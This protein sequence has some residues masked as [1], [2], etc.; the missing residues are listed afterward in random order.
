[1]IL[2]RL[3]VASLALAVVLGTAPSFAADPFYENLLAKGKAAL[4]QGQFSAAAHDLRIACFGL[5]DEPTSLAVGLTQLTLA[6]HRTGNATAF[7]EATARLLDLETRFSAYS[8]AEI[9]PATRA[10]FEQR[11]V[12]A[13]PYEQLQRLPAFRNAARARREQDVRALPPDRRRQELESL[14]ESAPGDASWRIM[15]AEL[16]LSSGRPANAR[17]ALAALPEL[18]ANDPH[19]QCLFGR[20]QAGLGAC[21]EAVVD[22]KACG[23]PASDAGLAADLV[24]CLTATGDWQQAAAVLDAV[25]AAWRGRKPLRALD[26]QTRRSLK[27]QAAAP[28]VPTPM[29]D[30][31]DPATVGD[32]ATSVVASEE[33]AGPPTIPVPA[34]PTP[35][36]SASQPATTAATQAPPPPVP[37]PAQPP[38][39]A[40]IDA[41]RERLRATNEKSEMESLLEASTSLAEGHPATPETQ[42]LV[43]EVA[44]R[45][46]RWSDVVHF[47]Q[48]GGVVSERPALQFY[49]AIALYETGDRAAAAA[50]MRSCL[51]Q[52]QRTEFVQDYAQKI[53]GKPQS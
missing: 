39:T 1:M 6:H 21:T 12:E 11:L 31:G 22:L 32:P 35:T 8:D 47:I 29:P 27:R 34:P 17:N 10:A 41:L 18:R 16:D 13:V 52:L 50:A 45:L 26:R 28:P 33:S 25:P 2:I 23:D 14:I 30:I 51:P 15:L 38:V 5:L 44:Y 36:I 19:A 24:T 7:D 46:R 53:L 40:R 3:A 42:F 20:A 43:A 48:Q 37:P 49:L 9:D 4:A